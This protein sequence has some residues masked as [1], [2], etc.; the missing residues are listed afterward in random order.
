MIFNRTQDDV[1][2]ALRL[3]Q[4][5]VQKFFELT[6]SEVETLERGMISTNTLNR[7][8][9]KQIELKELLENIG[10]WNIPIVNKEWDTTKIFN[11]DDFRRLVDN[12]N[13]L[14]NAFFVYKDTP[15]VPAPLFYFSN[16]NDMEKILYDIDV[17]I[18]DV[19]SYVR[20]CGTFN[21]GEE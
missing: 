3:R 1:N 15:A 13:I 19:N 5:K 21:T 8:E 20:E 9:S 16:L 17:M 10:Y 18:N 14:I 11:A 7:I 4:E 6:K 12:N 2:N